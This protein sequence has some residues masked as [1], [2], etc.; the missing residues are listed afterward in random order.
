VNAVVD[1]LI[2]LADTLDDGVRWC[3]TTLGIA[4][5]PGGKHPL[6]GTENRLF[7]I[8]SPAFPRAF[9]EILALDPSAP[10]P[11]RPRWF[12]L[13]DPALRRAVQAAPR[14]IHFVARTDDIEGAVAALAAE[15]LDP[16]PSVRAVR[17]I[18]G[19]LLEWRITVR[20]DGRRL[21]DG[22][23]P[24]LIQW[25]PVHPTGSMAES[26]VSLQSL[27]A[28]HPRADELDRAYRSIGLSGVTLVQGSSNLCA[29]LQ[30]PKG[31]VTLDL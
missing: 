26:G 23:L 24:T 27:A 28:S 2:V 16:G 22:A 13:D 12:D 10:A 14:L 8:A 30:T 11:G 19:G 17:T 4:P 15:G 31:P 6:M 18:G 3:E 20:D 29:V 7:S 25:G 21:F 5:G 9:F 1:H